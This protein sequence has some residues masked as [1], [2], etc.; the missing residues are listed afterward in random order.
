MSLRFT[1]IIPQDIRNDGKRIVPQCKEE[2]VSIEEFHSQTM[3]HSK[4]RSKIAFATP[5]KE[6]MSHGRRNISKQFQEGISCFLKPM[7]QMQFTS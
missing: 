3:P 1:G 4:K 7:V 5:E 2:L 6:V